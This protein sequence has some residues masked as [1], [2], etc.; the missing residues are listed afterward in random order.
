[1]HVYILSSQ[2]HGR[3]L[4]F[5]YLIVYPYSL[6]GGIDV[7]MQERLISGTINNVF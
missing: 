6:E 5:I 3:I 4:C 7:K 2:T 1:M